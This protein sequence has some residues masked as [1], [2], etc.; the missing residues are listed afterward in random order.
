MDY[1]G[2]AER[3]YPSIFDLFTLMLGRFFL[4]VMGKFL[5]LQERKTKSWRA[6][7]YAKLII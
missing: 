1:S 6:N 5:L 4:M 2:G 7:F 3:D